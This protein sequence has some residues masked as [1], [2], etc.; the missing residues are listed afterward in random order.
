MDTN[1]KV[2]MENRKIDYI[3]WDDKKHDEQVLFFQHHYHQL[4]LSLARLRKASCQFQWFWLTNFH[5]IFPIF[6]L[7]FFRAVIYVLAF[8]TIALGRFFTYVAL[9]VIH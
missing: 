4:L 6:F 5:M 1:R 9:F 2:A 7:T 8:R 3:H